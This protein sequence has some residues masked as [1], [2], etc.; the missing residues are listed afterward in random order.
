MQLNEQ[1]YQVLNALYE[2]CKDNL[3]YF[4]NKLIRAEGPHDLEDRQ[5]PILL[6]P[7]IGEGLVHPVIVSLNEEQTIEGFRIDGDVR[8]EVEAILMQHEQTV[9]QE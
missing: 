1:Q 4:G 8:G 6:E 2:L 5:I 9:V 7:I 3:N